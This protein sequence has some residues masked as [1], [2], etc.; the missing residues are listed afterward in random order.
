MKKEEFVKKVTELA[1]I[2]ADAYWDKGQ[3][4]E[5]IITADAYELETFDVHAEGNLI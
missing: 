5:I 1:Q 3:R 2:T 4:I